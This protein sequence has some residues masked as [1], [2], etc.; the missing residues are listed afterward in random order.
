MH[1]WQIWL[2]LGVV[3]LIFEMFHQGFVL[4]CFSIGC[5][6]GMLAALLHLG[7]SW[8]L[9]FFS[10]GTFLSLIGIRPFIIHFME[11]KQPTINTNTDALIGKTGR[12][13]ETINPDSSEGRVKIG[14][15][16]WWAISESGSMINKDETVTITKIEGVKVF[17]KRIDQ[18]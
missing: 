12:V 15:E 8:Q 4:I 18:T 17:V 2:I 5:F 3:T 10:I 16:D 13:I 14:G 1:I 7:I 9:G 6:L 11:K